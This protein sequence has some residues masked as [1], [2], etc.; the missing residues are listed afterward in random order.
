M[1]NGCRSTPRPAHPLPVDAPKGPACFTPCGVRRRA[2][3]VTLRPPSARA[4]RVPAE[5]SGNRIPID[6]P[7]RAHWRAHGVAGL[8]LRHARRR[9]SGRAPVTLRAPAARP[10]RLPANA[11][12]APLPAASQGARFP[13]RAHRREQ[14]AGR[15]SRSRSNRTRLMEN[16]PLYPPAPSARDISGARP[17]PRAFPPRRLPGHRHLRRPV[18]AALARPAGAEARVVASRPLTRGAA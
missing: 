6:A 9:A 8:R 17:A 13:A 12:G 1:G 16:V 15:H 14:G 2:Q 3:T 5:V 18:T 7:T 11:T 4:L 10:L